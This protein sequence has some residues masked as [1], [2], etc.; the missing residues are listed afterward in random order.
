[1]GANG[2]TGEFAG[3][4]VRVVSKNIKTAGVLLR[5]EVLDASGE[6][7]SVLGCKSGIPGRTVGEIVLV[8]LANNIVIPGTITHIHAVHDRFRAAVEAKRIPPGISIG[9][10]AE[11]EGL[12]A[13]ESH[14]EVADLG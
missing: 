8:T 10:T 9:R 12:P 7:V 6:T 5:D 1:M 11:I 13:A 14:V 4:A 2:K 3:R